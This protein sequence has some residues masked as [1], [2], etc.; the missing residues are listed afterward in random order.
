MIAMT[1]LPLAARGDERDSQGVVVSVEIK[2]LPCGPGCAGALPPTGGEMIPLLVW[3][4][5]ALVVM[6]CLLLLG[7]RRRRAADAAQFAQ[8]GFPA[9]G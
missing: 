8:S 4:T 9:D 3:V 2:P 1:A 5:V 7:R 6:G